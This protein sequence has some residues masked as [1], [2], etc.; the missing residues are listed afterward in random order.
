[1]GV[2]ADFCCWRLLYRRPEQHLV[3][4]VVVVTPRVFKASF[5]NNMPM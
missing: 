2:S 1:M 5:L 3:V 4:V